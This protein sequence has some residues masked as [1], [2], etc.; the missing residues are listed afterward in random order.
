MNRL[1]PAV[2]TV[3]MLALSTGARASA[4][5]LPCAAPVLALLAR[6]LQ[7]DHFVPGRNAFG[8]D[9]AGVI[10]SSTCKRMPDDPRLTLAAVAWDAGRTD[11]KSLVLAIVDE[12][13]ASVVASMKDEIYEDA[14]TQVHNGS[15]RLDTAAYVLAPGVR[16]F[17]L[18]ISSDNPG[19]GD[20]GLGP[21]RSLYVRDGASLRPVVAGLQLSQYRYVRGNQARCV[22]DPKEAET[23]IVENFKV[24]IGLGG[25]GR[26][27]W[28]EL[29]MTAT[30]SRSDGRPGRAPLQVR[31]PYD[32]D[33]YPLA[34]FVKA[35]DQ[36][37]K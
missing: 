12:A 29:V 32:G 26:G 16:A 19:C 37:R 8:R 25:A 3:L 11:S 4:E 34:P 14:V 6:Q 15:L 23:A 18:D 35:C 20:D 2:A 28:R 5:G 13:S 1:L 21:Q 33:A 24:T 31:V 27:G 7:V 30:S 36:W 9:P 10:L 22:S 17:G